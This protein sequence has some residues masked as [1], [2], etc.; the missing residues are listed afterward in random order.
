MNRRIVQIILSKWFEILGRTVSRYPAYFIIIPV[1]ITL[2]LFPGC[3][4]FKEITDI[5]YLFVAENGE[6][7]KTK[8]KV[9]KLFPLNMSECADIP[10]ITHRLKSPSVYVL[11]IDTEN[12][13]QENILKEIKMLDIIVKNLTVKKNE[14]DIGYEEFC[15]IIN[16]RCFVNPILN[17]ISKL[18]KRVSNWNKIKYPIDIDPV[19]FS[20]EAY[21]INLGGVT[22]DDGDYVKNVRALRLVYLMDETDPEKIVSIEKW[23]KSVFKKLSEVKFKN[24]RVIPDF[25]NLVDG[26]YLLYIKGI[27]PFIAVS[28]ILIMIFSAISFLTNSWK[29]SKPWLGISSCISAG[30]AICSSFGFASYCGLEYSATNITIPFL[31][32]AT[33]IDD[34]C[35]L[36]ASWRSTDFMK[37]V[38]KRLSKTYSEAAVSITLTSLTNFI[39]YCIGMTTPFPIVRIFCT[40]A[41]I[42]ILFTFLYQITFFGGCIAISGFREYNIMQ[43]SPDYKEI[44]IK[45]N[46]QE[47][48][49]KEEICMKFFRDLIDKILSST[50]AKII[51]ILLYFTNLGI[52][53]WGIFHLVEGF[54]ISKVF[55]VDYSTESIGVYYKYFTQFSLPIQIIIEE[56][57]NYAD[58]QVQQ[59]IDK[60][61]HK[62][63]SHPHISSDLTVWWLKYYNV[64]LN[65]DI[66]KFSL[67]GYNISLKQDFIDGL[68]NVFF[69]FKS[70][71]PFRYD[72]KFNKNG[73]KI[74]SSRIIFISKNVTN[75]IEEIKLMKDVNKIVKDS[76]LSVKVFSLFE[77][78]VEQATIIRS[79]IFQLIWVT[80]LIIII[81]FYIFIP[82]I[83]CTILV[84]ISVV[85]SVAETIGLMAFWDINLDIISTM[86][87]VLC[88]GF[89]INYPSHIVFA[90]SNYTKKSDNLGE[91]LSFCAYLVGF[92]IFQGS[93]STIVGVCVFLFSPMYVFITFFKIVFIIVM[94]TAFHSMFFIPVSID[95]LNKAC[96][97][98]KKADK[99]P[100]S[101]VNGKI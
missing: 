93:L 32:I 53:I 47:D 98:N 18:E 11:G 10:R 16:G 92:P 100:S 64:F 49:F 39:S 3:L 68:R 85:S 1:L 94:Q 23:T 34:S 26:S 87:L 7:V 59:S 76:K 55:P 13:L 22:V 38:E 79:I 50:S 78:V 70:A 2:I 56:P 27:T 69:R 72:V 24:I 66:A 51:I 60:L 19:T 62:M 33:E 58:P 65:H 46:S 45:S 67:K 63:E 82:Y 90:F 101:Q 88:F 95:F 15:G 89:C 29:R 21:G 12:M 14:L 6:F 25:I 81:L 86:I 17:V 31:V 97:L 44:G 84:S 74:V 99:N 42:S 75:R 28:I 91:K 40:Y 57:L 9:E 83:I 30:L 61:I 36:L 43:K 41:A 80:I 8:E 77:N 37:S 35:I 54:D 48:I 96:C 73:T 4:N 5:D 71:Y 20:Y 52:G